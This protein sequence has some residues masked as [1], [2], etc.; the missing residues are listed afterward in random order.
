MLMVYRL[1]KKQLPMQRSAASKT[2]ARAPRRTA[3]RRYRDES[4][5]SCRR[6]PRARGRARSSSRRHLR[7]GHNDDDH[8]R[9]R[10]SNRHLRHG[11]VRGHGRVRALRHARSRGRRLSFLRL[12]RLIPPHAQVRRR[13]SF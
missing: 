13:E 9:A 5:D 4:G 10:S 8:D 3:R 12:S 6:P 1:Q 2:S 7:H 11:D